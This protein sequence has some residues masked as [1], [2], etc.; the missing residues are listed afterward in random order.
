MTF[1]KLYQAAREVLNPR[2]IA[3]YSYAGSVASALL[4]SSGKIYTG[5]CIDTP[6][7]MGCCAEQA[8]I[9]TMITAGESKIVKIL[10]VYKDGNIIPPCG[11]CREY[12]SKIH[13]ENK[14]CLVKV[15]EETVVTLEELLP[16]H[17]EK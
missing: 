5:V 8:A 1:E 17:W 16:L 15:N 10:A 2:Q 3:S 13:D 12:I 7:S 14:T 4:T 11:K 6:G 9:A